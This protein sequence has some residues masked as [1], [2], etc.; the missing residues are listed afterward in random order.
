MNDILAVGSSLSTFAVGV[1]VVGVITGLVPGLLLRSFLMLYPKGDHQREVGLPARW[2][3]D[4]ERRRK[5]E[6]Q[7]LPGHPS[8]PIIISEGSLGITGYSRGFDEP[9]SVSCVDGHFAEWD[10]S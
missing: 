4:R 3:A 5:P 2:R 1:L 7:R 8:S 10:R 9:V 6:R